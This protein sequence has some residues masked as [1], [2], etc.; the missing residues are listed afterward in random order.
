MLLV[1]KFRLNPVT[2]VF[3]LDYYTKKWDEFADQYNIHTFSFAEN[4]ASFRV[5]S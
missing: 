4:C 3:W 1:L 2:L 5:E